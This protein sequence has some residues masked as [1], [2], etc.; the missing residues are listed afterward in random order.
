M[1]IEGNGAKTC[2]LAETRIIRVTLTKEI[3]NRDMR[4]I[5][6]EDDGG[7]GSVIDGA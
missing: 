2:I 5:D 3:A 7:I 4:R 1:V 6:S